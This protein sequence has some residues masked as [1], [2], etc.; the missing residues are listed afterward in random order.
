MLSTLAPSVSK[1]RLTLAFCSAKPNWM[2]RNPKLMFQMS[3]KDRRGLGRVV[4]AFR[5]LGVACCLET[6]QQAVD[7]WVAEDLVQEPSHRALPVRTR[8]GART[9]QIDALILEPEI[10]EPGDHERAVRA[11]EPFHH[12]GQKRRG[13]LHATTEPL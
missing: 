2:P 4:M 11:T 10:L 8:R 6:T 5:S 7:V 1:I 12:L 13:L 9:G 3:Q